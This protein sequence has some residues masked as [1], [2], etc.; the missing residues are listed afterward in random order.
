M[1]VTPNFSDLDGCLTGRHELVDGGSV[2][3][4][5]VVRMVMV[6]ISRGCTAGKAEAQLMVVLLRESC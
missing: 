3:M 1:R 6:V 4:V 2:V 5:M